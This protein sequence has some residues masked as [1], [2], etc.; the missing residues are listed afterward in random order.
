M[1]KMPITRGGHLN[2]PLSCLDVDHRLPG[3]AT[4][5]AILE[6]VRH[7]AR[8][9]I[10]HGVRDISYLTGYLGVFWGMFLDIKYLF[11]K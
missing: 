2:L 1:Q 7:D 5:N 11:A 9:C 4:E 8:P 10:V 6:H 3:N